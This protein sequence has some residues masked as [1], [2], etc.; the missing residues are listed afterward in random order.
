MEKWIAVLI[1][2]NIALSVA[3]WTGMNNLEDADLEIARH[4]VKTHNDIYKGVN[5]H[6]HTD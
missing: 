3:F 4:I 6:E 5:E 1:G 2:W